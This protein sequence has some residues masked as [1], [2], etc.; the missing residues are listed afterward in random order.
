MYAN[1]SCIQSI[2]QWVCA[3]YQ[4]RYDKCSCVCRKIISIIRNVNIACWIITYVH[5]PIYFNTLLRFIIQVIMIIMSLIVF[6]LRWRH[7]DHAGVSN[8]QPPGCLLNR[9][10]RRKSKKTSKLRVTGLCAGN[11]PGTGELPAQMASYEENVSIWW[12]HHGYM[13]NILRWISALLCLWTRP[14]LVDIM[15]CRLFGT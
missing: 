14:L 7:N 9:L 3:K 12:R 13:I 11:S 6:P 4:D 5:M 1:I 2:L 15:G 10:F 8:H